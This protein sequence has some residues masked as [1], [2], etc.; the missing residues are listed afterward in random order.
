M[1]FCLKIFNMSRHQEIFVELFK[2]SGYTAKQ[3]GEWS[4][5]HE[6]TL[7]RF[8]NGKSD[9]KAGDFFDLLACFPEEFQ[10][11]F[12]IRFRHVKGDWRNLIMAASPKDFEEI[13]RLMGDW[14]AIHSNS[15][16]LGKTKVAL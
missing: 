2:A 6:S 10:E 3:V 8:I 14:W 4:G 11:Q 12:W 13:C 5:L 1:Q 9:M 16:D 7:S 15:T